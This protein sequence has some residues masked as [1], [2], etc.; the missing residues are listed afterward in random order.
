[1]SYFRKFVSFL[2]ILVLLCGITLTFNYS[3]KA[4]EPDEFGIDPWLS[5]FH[6]SQN[7][8]FSNSILQ[9]PFEESW[10]FEGEGGQYTRFGE[11]SAIYNNVLYV[12]NIS[13]MRGSSSELVAIDLEE[14]EELWRAEVDGRL[15]FGKPAIA[16]DLELIYIAT[17][18]GYGEKGTGQSWVSAITF[19]GDVEWSEDVQGAIFG[20]PLYA[21][22]GVYVQT[23]YAKKV[24][25][26]DYDTESEPGELIKLN[27]EDGSEE[28]IQELKGSM[29]LLDLMFFDTPLA[30]KD[31]VVF[32][33]SS[34][35]GVNYT[36]GY[37]YFL[38]NSVIYAFDSASGDLIWEVDLG[39]E[40][41]LSGGVSCDDENVYICWHHLVNETRVLEVSAFE[42]DTGDLVWTY[43]MN[44]G[45]SFCSTP[46][47][48]KEHIFIN[49]R[50]GNVIAINKESGKKSWSKKVGDITEATM[51]ASNAGY[52]FGVATII[53][54]NKLAGS[55]IQAFDLEAKGK[56]VWKEDI[57][58]DIL[59]HVAIYGKYLILTGNLGIYCYESEMP[60]L[61]VSPE[62]LEIGEIERNIIKD[63]PI[64]VQNKGKEGLEGKVS[65]DV[66]WIKVSPEKIDDK[67]KEL[68]VTI[69]TH[70]LELKEYSGNIIIE[71]N[72]GNKKITVTMTVVDTTP[73]VVEFDFSDLINLEDKYYTNNPNYVLKGK[74]EQGAILEIGGEEVEIDSEGNFEFELSLKEGENK[75]EIKTADDVGNT[76]TQETIIYLDTTPPNITL[77][78]QNYTLSKEPNIYIMGQLDEKNAV[79]T[80]NGD[81]VELAPNG[82]FAVLVFL[83]RGENLFEIKA[84]DRIGNEKVI[85]LTIVY[86]ENVLIVLNVGKKTGEVNAK[87]V[88]LDVAPFIHKKTGRT[89]VP[90]RFIGEALGAKVDWDNAE[91]K[92]TYTLYGRTIELWIDK[93]TALVNGDPV[94]VDPA[95]YIVSGRTVVPLRFVSEN[96]G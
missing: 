86:P 18:D 19:D 75:I 79:I 57:D 44:G 5:I 28:W 95:P 65:S 87:T 77:A 62:K 69:D 51:I 16:P 54:N 78:T 10:V 3:V 26:K 93:S 68:I 58:D 53:S 74:T 13:N 71:S 66:S 67:T 50:E 83:K 45:I 22:D 23:L 29:F 52:A 90:L 14:G 32:A 56:S 1:M 94:V 82:S 31:D 27:A 84:V 48:G 72:G 35:L 47:V 21:D 9:P 34:N 80:I 25:G 24:E 30:Y 73:P 20:S 33:A 15:A 12:Q 89:M 17:S 88:N 96:L 59:T 42:I 64:S 39:S 46:L 63:N 11:G 8:G 55:R 7:T 6:D 41:V 76:G 85:N 91:R 38:P 36:K 61:S 92:V 40:Y 81:K 4:N 70:G 43:E 37:I 49:D 60:E 2:T